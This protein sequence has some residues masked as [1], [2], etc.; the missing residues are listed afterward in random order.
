MEKSGGNLLSLKFNALS[1]AD[2]GVYFLVVGDSS[3]ESFS[4]ASKSLEVQLK[5]SCESEKMLSK[6]YVHQQG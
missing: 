4:E 1:K 3:S 5:V 2:E 6:Y